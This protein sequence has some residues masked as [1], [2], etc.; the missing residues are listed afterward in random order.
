MIIDGH[1]HLWRPGLGFD[2]KP[3]RDN[4]FF[5]TRDWVPEDIEAEL[6]RLGID[7]VVITQSAPDIAET[8]MMLAHCRAL[9]F[10]A[11]VVGWVDLAAADVAADIDRLRAEPKFLGVRA[12]LRRMPDDGYILRPAVRAGLA[13]LAQR[14][15][16][17]VLL[18]E[19]RHHDACLAVLR[20]MPQIRAVLNHGGMPDIAAG[21]LALWART[22]ARYASETGVVTQLSGLVSLAGPRWSL[23]TIRP[24][25]LKLFDIFGPDR[26]M[27][28]SDWPLALLHGVDYARWWDIATGF[29][30]ELKLDKRERQAVLG[31]VAARTYRLQRT[32]GSTSVTPY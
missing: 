31:D 17:V 20:D 19:Q 26:T 4:P 6:T 12:Q 21:D 25:A 30:D 7:R 28:T 3:V 13:A 2:V 24:V 11:G 9:P 16:A 10:V 29:L 14:D 5:Q 8:D 1:A 22:M 15:L 18:S 32:D 27:F 23:E